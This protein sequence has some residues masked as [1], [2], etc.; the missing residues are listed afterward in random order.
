MARILINKGGSK[1]I[2]GRGQT[3][4]GARKGEVSGRSL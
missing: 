4:A 3:G 1:D 2:P